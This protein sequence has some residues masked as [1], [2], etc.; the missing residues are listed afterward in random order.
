MLQVSRERARE[1]L[2]ELV[3]SLDQ[4]ERVKTISE[5]YINPEFDSVLESR[6]IE[7]LKRM[8]GIAGLPPVKLLQDIVNGKSGFMLDL[9]GQRYRIEPQRNVDASDGVSVASKPD[10]MIWPWSSG[11]PRRPIA[12]FCDGWEHHQHSIRE[13]ALKRSALVASGR[14]WIW[15]VTHDDVTKALAGDPMTDLDS[16]LVALTLHSGEAVT[17]FLPRAQQNA[18]TYNAVTLLLHYLATPTSVSVDTAAVQ[19][20]KNAMWLNFLMIPSNEQEKQWVDTGINHWMPQLPQAMQSQGKSHAPCLSKRDAQPMVMAWW[21]LSYLKSQDGAL[22]SP[23]LVLL[24]DS[25]INDNKKL[26]LDWRR[27]LQVFNTLQTL[28]GFRMASLLGLQNK[29][30]ELL[31]DKDIGQQASPAQPSQ[32]VWALEWQNVVL[33]S[34]SSLV[35]GLR[36]LADAQ[37]TP[38]VVGYEITNAKGQVTADA[39]LAWPTKQLVVLR[40]DQD[41]LISI[42]EAAS[43]HVVLLDEDGLNVQMQAW[44]SVVLAKL[45]V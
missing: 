3:G 24:D 6:F 40:A 37:L 14:F 25:I 15:S 20:Q 17:A 16:P 21:P 32:I 8:S 26:R 28:K 5:I 38:P 27:W 43:W 7:S 12:I 2:N 4:L 35:P 41:D 29:D 10:F 42:W 34:L 44:H 45:S 30:L 18:F 23:G 11:G 13:D 1:V 19:L 31:H 36:I 33:Q 22:D 9:G 39:E